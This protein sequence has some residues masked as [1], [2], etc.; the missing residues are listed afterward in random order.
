A[1]PATSLWSTAATL[2]QYDMVL[3]SCQGGPPTDKPQASLDNINAFA[4]AGG[5]VYMSHYE[6]FLLWPTG[7]TSPWS[8]VAV[9]DTAMPT[10][11]ASNVA[12]DIGF[13]K[14]E[15]LAH[16]AVTAGASTML[17]NIASIANSRDDVTSATG[18]TTGWLTGANPNNVYQIA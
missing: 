9:Q 8:T 4:A 14:G 17:G 7:E 2:D 3:D 16:W 11:V 10:G 12:I 13:P 1:V 6:N 15:A 5:R 18:P